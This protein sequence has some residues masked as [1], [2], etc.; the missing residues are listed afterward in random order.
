MRYR[1]GDLVEVVW[2]DPVGTINE[3]FKDAD[4][5]R[6]VTRGTVLSKR[7]KRLVLWHSQYEGEQFGDT[8]VINTGCIDDARL[9]VGR[10]AMAALKAP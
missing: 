5:C 6:C 4:L 3:P 9:L 10:D 2:S 1:K 8:T 7:G